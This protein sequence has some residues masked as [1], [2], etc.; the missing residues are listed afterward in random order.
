MN[1]IFR[2]KR[3]LLL[4]LI[5]YSTTIISQS[6]KGKVVDNEGSGIPFVSIVS[7]GT[8]KGT[9]TNLD[10]E[11]N[12]QVTK[13]P[14][15]LVFS[16]VGFK[17]QE[18]TITTTETITVILE[19]DKALLDEVV[20]TGLASSVKRENLANAVSTISAKELVGNTGQAT[21]MVRYMVS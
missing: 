12:L 4:L 15:V 20:I 18:K 21:W 14:V 13:L 8:Q 3:W 2:R 19:E 1:T 16:S 10:G 7:K 17:T 6:L 5:S 11:F 9:E